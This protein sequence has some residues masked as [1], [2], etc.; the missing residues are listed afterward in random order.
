[1]AE[2][3]GLH[4]HAVIPVKTIPRTTSGKLQRYRLAEAFETGGYTDVLASLRSFMEGEGSV[5]AGSDVGQQLLNVCRQV[6][7]DKDIKPDQNLFELG[8]DSLTLV[9]IHEGIDARFPGKVE[10]TDLFDYPTIS[11]LAGYISTRDCPGAVN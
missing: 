6:F 9:K 10:V 3:T 1:L 8:A 7:P 11:S 2:H 5:S 4:A